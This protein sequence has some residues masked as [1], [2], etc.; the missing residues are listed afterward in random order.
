[1]KTFVILSAVLALAIADTYSTEH[2]DLDV[3]V[4]TN[5]EKLNKI[6]MCFLDKEPCDEIAGHFKKVL[7]DA[8]ETA[9][10]KCTAAQKH[11]L[12]RYLEEVKKTSPDDLKALKE[13]YD[14]DTKHIEALANAL[15]DA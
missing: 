9:C 3:E 10:A 12:K 5:P 14:P 6:T 7:P 1:M 13:K 8:T 2:D 15:K 4:F 11:I